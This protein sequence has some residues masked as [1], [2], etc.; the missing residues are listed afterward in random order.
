MT[1]CARCQ[2]LE[3]EIRS[4]RRELAYELERGKAD[5][6]KRA[7]RLT[8]AQSEI[9]WLLFTSNGRNVSNAALDDLVVG[10]HSRKRQG[11][12]VFKVQISHIRATMGHDSIETV[13]GIGYRMT[14]IGRLQCLEA[15]EGL[16][17]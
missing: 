1:H 13:L 4:L 14:D 17:A 6:L 7:L 2:E 15:I 16:R 8:T 11:F 10:R 3:D 9:V 5:T 12:D